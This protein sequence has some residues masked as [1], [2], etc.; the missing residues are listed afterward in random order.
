VKASSRQREKR[1]A[2][3]DQARSS[4]RLRV[5]DG[6]GGRR[7]EWK[8]EILP[9]DQVRLPRLMRE[10]IEAK[11]MELGEVLADVKVEGAEVS[12]LASE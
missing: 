1:V 12:A 4:A 3:Y 7:K 2:A 6:V 8:R 11:A 5:G 9:L 10:A